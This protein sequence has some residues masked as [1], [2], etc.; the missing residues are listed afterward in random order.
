MLS[1]LRFWERGPEARHKVVVQASSPAPQAPAIDAQASGPHQGCGAG[2]LAWPPKRPA[3]DMQASGPHQGCGAGVLV[4]PPK[5]PAIDMQASG[6]RSQGN[7]F[8]ASKSNSICYG[9]LSLRCHVSPF[10][11]ATLI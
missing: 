3:I 4:W 5:R 1:T 7:P 9:Q 11:T 10:Q 2:V 6:P 8:C